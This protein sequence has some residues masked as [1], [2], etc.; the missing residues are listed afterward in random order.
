MK[1]RCYSLL[2]STSI[3]GDFR[4]IKIVDQLSSLCYDQYAYVER[5]RASVV[6][7]PIVVGQWV[8]LFVRIV[9]LGPGYEGH[10]VW[11]EKSRGGGG[12]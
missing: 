12:V 11:G 7:R 4:S 9:V 3:G 1:R 10:E 2:R 6:C 5:A 8:V